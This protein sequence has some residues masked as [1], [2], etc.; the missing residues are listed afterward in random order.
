MYQT[1]SVYLDFNATCPVLP[2]IRDEIP[3]W[4]NEFH[5]NPSS[6]HLEGKKSRQALESARESVASIL[7]CS[8]RS[9]FFTSGA[10]E[11]IQTVFHHFLHNKPE[12]KQVAL[13]RA[14][15]M[16]TINAARFYQS[17]GTR[18]LW[19]EVDSCGRILSK[20]LQTAL[21]KS[22]DFISVCAANNETGAIENLDALMDNC[23]EF[24][25]PLHLDATQWIGKLPWPEN[26]TTG[27]QPDFISLSGHKFG[28]LKGVG[29][30][31]V[32]SKNQFTPLIPGGGQEYGLRGGTPSLISAISMGAAAEEVAQNIQNDLQ[33][34]VLL[35]DGLESRLKEL[36]PDCII[37][38]QKIKRLPNT[39]SISIPGKDAQSMVNSLSRKG[40][41]I[42]SGSACSTGRLEPSHVLSAM[43]LPVSMI[44]STIRIS[45]GSESTSNHIDALLSALEN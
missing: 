1:G 37:H 43:K 17:Q 45:L 8:S 42:S 44:S 34:I 24:D 15:H 7:D 26:P 3:L 35:R 38:S 40:I 28:A 25:I 2:S 31:V 14:E 18:I 12:R 4:L 27:H 19:I 23:S 13:P 29:A 30:L 41:A 11:S 22:P 6:P 21:E 16:A 5:G 9:L 33:R 36:F 39:T 10:S 32:N 20:S